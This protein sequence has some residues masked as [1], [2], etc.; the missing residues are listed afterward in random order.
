MVQVLNRLGHCVNY[1]KL[2]ELET[3]TAEKIQERRL[4]CPEGA[5]AGSPKGL[6]FD[7]FDDVTQMLSGADSLHDTLG[8][9]YQNIPNAEPSHHD[10]ARGTTDK[11]KASVTSKAPVPKKSSRKRT[12]DTSNWMPLAPYRKVPKMTSFSYRNTAVFSI[13]DVSTRARHLDLIWMI[14]HAL[15]KMCFPCW[16]ALIPAF[17]QTLYQSRKSSTR[18]ICNS[19]LPALMWC[20]THL[21]QLKNMCRRV[22][23]AL[24]DS[25]E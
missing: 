23:A 11:G 1:N 19:P 14:I 8:I 21:S 24:W 25:H 13:P 20:N 6:A 3:T 4:T 10:V 16:W 7:N 17:P 15:G 18:Q 22:Q 2:E 12:L 9:I 5:V